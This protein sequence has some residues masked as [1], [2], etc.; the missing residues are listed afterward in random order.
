MSSIPNPDA[1]LVDD[2]TQVIEPTRPDMP[3][4]QNTDAPVEEPGPADPRPETTPDKEFDTTISPHF[5]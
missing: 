1:P 5:L 3:P 2:P 4:A